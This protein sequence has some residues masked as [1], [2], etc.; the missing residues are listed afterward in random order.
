MEYEFEAG[1]IDEPQ[2][3][4][5]HGLTPPGTLSAADKQWVLKWYPPMSPSLPTLKAFETVTVELAAGQPIDVV[6]K[7]TETRKYKIET[8]GAT[9]TVM[10]LFENFG[11]TPRYLSGDDDSGEDRNASI[12]YRL[13][14]GRTYTVRLRVYNPGQSGKTSLIYS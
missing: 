4:D 9:D 1:L 7:P 8:R 6:I 12:T 2:E 10:V 14:R 11:D 3:C 5:L 13:F